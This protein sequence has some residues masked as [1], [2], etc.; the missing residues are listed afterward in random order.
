MQLLLRQRAVPLTAWTIT[1]Q[2]LP[3]GVYIASRTFSVLNRPPP[4]YRGH[5]P[6]T[7]IE[8]SALVV[9]SAIGSLL[10]PRRAGVYDI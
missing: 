3:S 2:T 7:P 1:F 4:N 6:L 10:N 5:V 8:R 9:S